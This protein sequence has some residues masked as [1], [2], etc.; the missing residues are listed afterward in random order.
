MSKGIQ[1]KVEQI[2][3]MLNGPENDIHLLGISKSKL[4]S[5]NPNNFFGINKLSTFP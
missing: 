4:N 5:D 3:L 1:N 2:G